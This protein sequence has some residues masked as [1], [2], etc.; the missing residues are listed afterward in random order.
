L[1]AEIEA[2]IGENQ[3]GYQNRTVKDLETAGTLDLLDPRTMQYA[4]EFLKKLDV[5]YSEQL[6][7]FLQVFDASHSVVVLTKFY[8]ASVLDK[9]GRYDDS[10]Q[11]YTELAVAMEHAASAWG[12]LHRSTLITWSQAAGMAF[13]LGR[14]KD[15]GSLYRKVFEGQIATLTLRHIET[16]RTSDALSLVL[17][18]QGNYQEAEDMSRASVA[19]CTSLLGADNPD[20]LLCLSNLSNI[21]SQRG[22]HDEALMHLTKCIALRE[23]IFGRGNGDT[24]VCRSNLC[25]IHTLMGNYEAA[26]RLADE[27][28]LEMQETLG[29]EHPDTFYTQGTLISTYHALG[30]HNDARAIGKPLL[31]KKHLIGVDNP[32]HL[33]I[34][35]N[36]SL[37]LQEEGAYEES[38]KM[39]WEILQRRTEILGESHP[40]TLTSLNNIASALQ[41]QGKYQEAMNIYEKI[42]NL[43]ESTLGPDH[44]ATIDTQ[45]NKAYLLKE[46]GNYEVAL[47]LAQDAVTR[48]EAALGPRHP[49]T[50]TSKS[51]LGDI[52]LVS[53]DASVAAT[54]FKEVLETRFAVLGTKHRD[55]MLSMD[56]LAVAQNKMGQYREAEAIS[57]A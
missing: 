1:D 3:W 16:I 29:Q 39:D 34:M 40:D 53:G 52:H 30:R 17:L 46:V 35:S 18:H 36:L 31:D 4:D 9:L 44:P 7:D 13:K 38:I 54:I 33:M 5:H 50:L 26:E 8:H 23:K 19:R 51:N 57:A 37:I 11:L 41:R 56:Q 55:T 48:G 20:T 12:N 6:L 25:A 14:M 10:Y 15:A 49:H 28:L 32:Y 45:A 22:K 27:V 24:M 2:I 21:L 47:A 42:L 43:R